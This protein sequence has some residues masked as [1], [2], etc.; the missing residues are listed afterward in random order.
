MNKDIRGILFWF[1]SDLVDKLNWKDT[2]MD[3][4]WRIKAIA[5]SCLLWPVSAISF[6]FKVN[7]NF[8][9]F[10]KGR[11][12]VQD[13]VYSLHADCAQLLMLNSLSK[14]DL[15]HSHK[16]WTDRL[17]DGWCSCQYKTVWLHEKIPTQ[18]QRF[19]GKGHLMI[20]FPISSHIKYGLVN[21]ESTSPTQKFTSPG[22]VCN[23]FFWS[24][25]KPTKINF[26]VVAWWKNIKVYNIIYLTY[27]LLNNGISV[28]DNGYYKCLNASSIILHCDASMPHPELYIIIYHSIMRYKVN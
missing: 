20:N 10:W 23:W 1:S 28:S 24:C 15:D 18:C 11:K 26:M 2:Y 21:M 3:R 12:K 22:P 5:A 19:Y 17:T 7:K 8:M 6:P 27:I 13:R 25:K 4:H 9:T 14:K 16:I